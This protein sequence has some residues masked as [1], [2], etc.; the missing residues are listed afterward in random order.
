MT[1]DS[2]SESAY[3]FQKIWISEI[4]LLFESQGLAA[5]QAEHLMVLLGLYH[6]KL[7]SDYDPSST[8]ICFGI[9]RMLP[10]D[11]VSFELSYC[12]AESTNLEHLHHEV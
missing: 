5:D 9:I 4:I 10:D 3:F 7:I 8:F 11:P 12:D 1:A 2:F 6:L